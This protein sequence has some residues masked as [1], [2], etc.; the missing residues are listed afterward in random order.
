MA[1]GRDLE[2]TVGRVCEHDP[3][4]APAL[5][6]VLEDLEPLSLAAAVV[7]DEVA[8]IVAELRSTR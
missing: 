4:A 8:E 5:A 3:L 1:E 6:V 7:V 2:G